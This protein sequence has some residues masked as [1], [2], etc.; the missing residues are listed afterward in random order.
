MR[1]DPGLVCAVQMFE[2]LMLFQPSDLLVNL[3]SFAY[4]LLLIKLLTQ[5]HVFIQPVS[6]GFSRKNF[7]RFPVFT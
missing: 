6:F 2:D 4:I 3:M 7:E 1:D 5:K